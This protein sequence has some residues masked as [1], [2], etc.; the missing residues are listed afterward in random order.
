VK[1]FAQGYIPKSD[2]RVKLAVY[3]L[4][5]QGASS[6]CWTRSSA[7]FPPTLLVAFREELG[8]TKVRRIDVWKHA[9]LKTKA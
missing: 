3:A 1:H 7:S 9:G 6:R 8:A 4:A 2:P 5:D